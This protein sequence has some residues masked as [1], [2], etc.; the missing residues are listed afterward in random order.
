MFLLM[1]SIPLILCSLG[2]YGVVIREIE[3]PTEAQQFM[4]G[5]ACL[6]PSILLM[7]VVVWFERRRHRV[8]EQR[9]RRKTAQKRY[10]R[11]APFNN[12]Q[13]LASDPFPTLPS[14]ARISDI[15]R[16][17]TVE[18]IKDTLERLRVHGKKTA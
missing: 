15:S 6:V 12:G 8:K 7:G 1:L 9:S 18:T 11:E 16:P 13:G 17:V 2:L 3:V 10:A 5:T 4:V 14:G